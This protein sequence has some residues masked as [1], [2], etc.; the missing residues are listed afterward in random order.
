MSQSG[1]QQAALQPLI[2]QLQQDDPLQRERARHQLAAQGEVAV[3]PLARL[4]ESTSTHVRWE[5]LKTL[6]AIAAPSSIP[7]LIRAFDDEMPGN[8]FLAAE[9]LIAIGEEALP[10]VLDALVRD[11]HAGWRREGAHHVL[12]HYASTDLGP[13]VRPVLAAMKAHEPDVA[14]PH[15]ADDARRKLLAG[16]LAGA[17]RRESR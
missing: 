2:D 3:A 17:Q 16:R 11:A 13:I 14:V 9:G 10:A 1:R 15:A 8:R 12:Y 5:A 4:L 6:E 7:I